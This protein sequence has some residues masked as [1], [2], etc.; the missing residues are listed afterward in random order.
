MAKGRKRKTGVKRTKSRRISRCVENFDKG[1][2]RA[3][4][5][6]ELYGQDGCDAIGR[7]YR[8]GLLGEGADAKA[9]LDTARAIAKAY[10]S[11]YEVG[12][13][14]NPLAD[15]NSGASSPETPEKARGR[16]EWLNGCMD[17]VNRLGA[18]QRRNFDALCINVNPDCGPH[19]LD[20]L[21][22]A[23]HSRRPV[24]DPADYQSL[25]FALDALSMLAGAN[26]PL[27]QRLNAA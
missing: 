18:P 12:R 11:A 8:S 16:E 14:F 2:D 27:R 4:A 23:R 3:Q 1:N 13:Y 22:L 25:T 26:M 24:F 17:R 10:W 6:Q 5:M 15:R 19:W 21:C 9:M 7:A 20:R